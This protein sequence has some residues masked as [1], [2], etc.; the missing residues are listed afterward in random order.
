[1]VYNFLKKK[2]LNKHLVKLQ[3]KLYYK[4]SHIF[5]LIFFL[6][7]HNIK[8]ILSSGDLELKNYNNNNNFFISR[9]MMLTQL[10]TKDQIFMDIIFQIISPNFLQHSHSPKK[11]P[12]IFLIFLSPFSEVKKP[13]NLSV[14]QLNV[15]CFD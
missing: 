14:K 5:L 11:N 15:R 10:K 4:S 7:K 12:P 2:L 13:S 8:Y 6:N 1:M 3:V 9:M